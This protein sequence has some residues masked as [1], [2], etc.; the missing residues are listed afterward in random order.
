LDNSA[1]SLLKASVEMQDVCLGNNLTSWVGKQDLTD[2]FS[3]S[4]HSCNACYK[5]TAIALEEDSV[6]S[7][8]IVFVIEVPRSLDSFVRL[9][10]RVED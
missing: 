6:L 8:M 10:F 3:I 2:G 9:S 7:P 4:V 1:A 5:V